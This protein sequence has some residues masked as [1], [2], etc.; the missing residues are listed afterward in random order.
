MAFAGRV[1]LAVAL[2][3]ALYGIGAALYGARHGRRDW[4]DSGRRSI[5]ALAAILTVAMVILEVAFIDNYFAYNTVAN[6]SSLST[7]L[8]YRVAAVWSS[9]EGSLL[10][11]VWLLS[12]WAS[13]AIFLTRNRLRDVVPYA[14]SVLLGF[15][16][17]FTML[18]VFFDSPFDQTHPAP[19]NG[20]GLEPLLR[21]SSMLIHP[22]MLYS[23]Y[24]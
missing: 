4:V 13:V 10:L 14:T 5:Y 9:Q 19:T 16:A 11:W 2:V 22:P 6:T 21:N 23:G 24:T 3:V 17:F 7:P 15:G 20:A 1:A 8:L 18:L 12:I